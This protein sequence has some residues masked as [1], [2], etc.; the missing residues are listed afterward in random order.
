MTKTELDIDL[1]FVKDDLDLS[2]LAELNK[3]SIMLMDIAGWQ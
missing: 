1:S 3:K 2:M